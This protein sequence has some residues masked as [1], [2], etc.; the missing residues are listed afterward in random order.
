MALSANFTCPV[1]VGEGTLSTSFSDTS[2]GGTPTTWKWILGDGTVYEGALFSTVYHTYKRPGLYTVTLVVT[3]NTSQ[4]SVT[5]VGYVAVNPTVPGTP[6]DI[7]RSYSPGL[8][9]HW[10]FYVTPEGRLSFE[11]DDTTY[12]SDDRVVDPGIWTL[13]EFHHQTRRM[14]VGSAT[15]YRR[16][17]PLHTVPPV[18][19]IMPA[20][21][22]SE[23]APETSMR[24]DD[25]MIRVGGVDLHDY[26]DSYRPSAGWLDHTS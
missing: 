15:H 25:L 5:R 9:R 18:V 14:F 19:V 2:T 17:V 8:G 11:D 23:V 7:M 4:G 24:V 3:N 22:I 16:S 26:F 1:R 12:V 20:A 10:R 13:V 21:D 6:Q